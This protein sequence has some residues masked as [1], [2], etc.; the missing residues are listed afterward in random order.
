[1]KSIDG[2]LPV[3]QEY[4]LIKVDYMGDNYTSCQNCGLAINMLA[5]L[6]SSER[7]YIVGVDCAEGL[8]GCNASTQWQIKQKSK[9]ANQTKRYLAK[10]KKADREGLLQV[11]NGWYYI[12]DKNTW[13][14]RILESQKCVQMFKEYKSKS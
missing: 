12:I 14:I 7:E 5:T 2:K 13:S 9:Q 6:K 1:M 8:M 11:K 10:L 4:N 3:N